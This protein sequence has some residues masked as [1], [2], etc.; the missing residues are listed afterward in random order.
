MERRYRLFALLVVALAT[1]VASAVPALAGGSAFGPGGIDDAKGDP[2][3]PGVNVI[4]KVEHNNTVLV[5]LNRGFRDAHFTIRLRGVDV[6]DI[7]DRG[8]RGN[9]LEDQTPGQWGVN[10]E[11]ELRT[12]FRD[13]ANPRKI[14]A[15]KFYTCKNHDTIRIHLGEPS[16][17]DPSGADVPAI[18]IVFT[19]AEL[20]KD[21]GVFVGQNP[22]DVG[23]AWIPL[24]G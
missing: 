9:G 7:N 24:Y 8:F 2:E 12:K 4:R 6:V 1:L 5:R 22:T 14:A 13:G 23:G 20:N 16:A 18:R 10:C 17:S 15:A 21:D 3:A 11:D 19:K